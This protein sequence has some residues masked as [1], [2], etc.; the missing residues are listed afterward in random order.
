M[1]AESRALLVILSTDQVTT[2]RLM[3]ML[4]Q[5]PG[6]ESQVVTDLDALVTISRHKGDDDVVS[7]DDCA[8]EFMLTSPRGGRVAIDLARCEVSTPHGTAPLTGQEVRV[9]TVLLR[10]P[11]RFHSASELANHVSQLGAYGVDRHCIEQTMSGL[12]RKLGE[13]AREP[14]WLVSRR[15][16]GYA[17]VLPE[18]EHLRKTG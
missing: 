8:A 11:G 9:L 5:L 13:N 2:R 3:D 6:A 14:H 10:A 16:L 17:F 1:E 4:S 7:V 12:R 18:P 15:G